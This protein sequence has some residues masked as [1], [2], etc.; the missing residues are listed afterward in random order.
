MASGLWQNHFTQICPKGVAS[1]S[2]PNL[3]QKHKM[4][5]ITDFEDDAAG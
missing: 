5:Q 4:L 2:G 3:I 1:I